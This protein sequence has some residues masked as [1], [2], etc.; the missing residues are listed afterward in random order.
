MKR[1]ARG[2]AE[3]TAKTVK[4]PAA[5]AIV[6]VTDDVRESAVLLGHLSKEVEVRGFRPVIIPASADL[7]S[8]ELR[9]IVPGARGTIIAS[10]LVDPAFPA[11]ADAPVLVIG[12]RVREDA[13]YDQVVLDAEQAG[14]RAAE[15]IASAGR[16]SVAIA[17]RYDRESQ[18]VRGFL[19]GVSTY[20]L[21]VPRDHIIACQPNRRD[22]SKHFKTFLHRVSTLP[23]VVYC[24][25]GDVACGVYEALYAEGFAVPND[26][27]IV[28]NG[29]SEITGRPFY[30]ITTIAPSSEVLAS[31]A[32]E[33]LY[34]RIEAFDRQPEVRHIAYEIMPGATTDFF[35][36]VKPA[37]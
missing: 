37:K 8:A 12:D 34:S 21:I 22:A 14:S 35:N 11:Y 3:A 6:I 36:V 10:K 23:H 2:T 13:P 25:D 24:T 26:V 1:E 33:L 15:Y 7:G 18:V 27:W 5:G 20:D 16:T 28:G 4:G 30:D 17:G 19:K 9:A 29:L 31:I 32:L